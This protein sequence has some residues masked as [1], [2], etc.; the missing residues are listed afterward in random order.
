MEN[1]TGVKSLS[2]LPALPILLLAMVC[3]G[4]CEW[5]IIGWFP[6]GSPPVVH[7]GRVLLASA[8]VALAWH[9]NFRRQ[10]KLNGRLARL[11]AKQENLNK[12][13]QQE[14][15]EREVAQHKLSDQLEFLQILIDAIPA[16]IFYKDS[17]GIYS[18]CNRAFEAFLGKPRDQIVGHSVYGVSPGPQARVY[19]EKDLELMRQRGHQTY[20][21]QVVYA[22]GTLHDVIFNKAA[23]ELED[24]RL[25]GLIGVILDIS[26]RKALERDLLQAKETAEFYSRSKTQFLTNM[27]H[28]IRTPLNA[29][30]G[31][32]Q[33]LQNRTAHLSPTQDFHD[34]L[35]KISISGQRLA[36]LVND[37]LDISRIEAGKTEVVEEDFALQNLINCILASCEPQAYSKGLKI[38]SH[39]DST[40]PK[41][42]LMDRGKVSQVLINLTA[43]AIK[44][45]P[46]RS[47]VKIELFNRTNTHIVIEV[48]DQGIGIP[49]EQ[50][51]IIFEPFEQVD[52][53]LDGQARGTGL[54]LPIA[55]RLVEL[56]GGEIELNSA[57]NT[58]TCFKVVLPLCEG[59]PVQATGEETAAPE[60]SFE[61]VQVLIFEDNM[62]NQALMQAF[63]DD[64]NITATFADD[65]YDGLEKAQ[66]IRPD[67]IF[68]D[69]QLP[70]LSGIE[71]TKQIRNDPVLRDTPVI[72]LSA[73][74]FSDQQNTARD[75][76][77]NDY[78]SKPIAFPELTE[79]IRKSL[80]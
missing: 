8:L 65:A 49:P 41:Y 64:L 71:A 47:E 21:S 79:A 18:G 22:D 6:Q 80:Q 66:A 52:K 57:K 9:I 76:G 43:N 72:G 4:T 20:E 33:I 40:L 58:G 16:P 61:G 44:F 11:L 10:K 13:N 7:I 63:C 46:E 32:S 69:V 19:H 73:A 26:E 70:G 62:L 3:L 78:L 53:T 17:E 68:M 28:E 15:R 29:I 50:Q 54:G 42:I 12:L 74:A 24:G 25:G 34:F 23:Y 35:Q 60:H 75:A 1:N 55:R 48:S 31:F 27:S 2:A 14:L 39:I 59:Q 38:S 67:L 45:S 36:D 30:V 56:L 51:A 77:M 5:V 37:V